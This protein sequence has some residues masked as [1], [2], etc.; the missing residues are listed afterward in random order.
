MYGPRTTSESSTASLFPGLGDREDLADALSYFFCELRSVF[1][2]GGHC[3]LY[4]FLFE[5]ASRRKCECADAHRASAALRRKVDHVRQIFHMIDLH[6]HGHIQTVA[7]NAR[8][9]LSVFHVRHQAK[10]LVG[11][12]SSLTPPASSADLRCFT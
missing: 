6:F 2:S 12:V 7:R 9:S 3:I 8:A 11:N 5:R 10:R 4:A 1:A